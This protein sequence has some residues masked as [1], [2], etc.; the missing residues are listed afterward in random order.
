M[1]ALIDLFLFCWILKWFIDHI[2]DQNY[3]KADMEQFWG[4]RFDNN[5]IVRKG[6]V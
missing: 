3:S 4:C 2:P 5:A 6:S 1:G